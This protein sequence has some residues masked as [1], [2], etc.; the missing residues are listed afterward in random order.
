MKA[1]S[2]I[3]AEGHSGNGSAFTGGGGGLTISEV[4]LDF[5]AAPIWSTSF[6]FSIAG[7][8]VGQRII[9]VPAGNSDELEMDGFSCAARVSAPGTITAYIVAIPGPVT[10][11]RAFNITLG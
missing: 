1:L 8:T 11:Q 3:V 4:T 9:M 7:A 5:G 6:S 2:D 10:G